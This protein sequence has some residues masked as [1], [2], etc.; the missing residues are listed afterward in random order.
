MR[1][2]QKSRLIS[3]TLCDESGERRAM[4]P[5]RR[6]LSGAGPARQS[7]RH[8]DP[9]RIADR[10]VDRVVDRLLKELTW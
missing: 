8:A 1:T 9:H 7:D 5:V 4:T 10:V 3:G 2:A 6:T